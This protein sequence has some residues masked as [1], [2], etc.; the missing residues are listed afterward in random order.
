MTAH[1]EQTTSKEDIPYLLEILNDTKSSDYDRLNV[2][3]PLSKIGGK[4]SVEHI[5]K[6]LNPIKDKLRLMLCDPGS[7]TDAMN[8]VCIVEL[9][10]IKDTRIVEILI[11]LLKNNKNNCIGLAAIKG[12]GNTGDAKAIEHIIPFMSSNNIKESRAASTSLEKLKWKPGNQSE[13]IRYLI[14]YNKWD[15]LVKIGEPAVKPLI[16][17]LDNQ[18]YQGHGIVEIGFPAYA[19]G[20]IGDRRATFPLMSIL[21]LIAS[22]YSSD[23]NITAIWDALDKL[24][25]EWRNGDYI[26]RAVSRIMKGFRDKRDNIVMFKLNT[27]PKEIVIRHLLKLLDD[28]DDEDSIVKL[29][30]AS[31]LAFRG[32][33]RAVEPLIKI[34]TSENKKRDGKLNESAAESLKKLTGQD[35]GPDPEKWQKW[36][37]ENKEKYIDKK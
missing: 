8:T 33:K 24:D 35:Y 19:L 26:N 23:A 22:D 31:A 25:P 12:L 10:N 5:V 18:L 11:Y 37:E 13:K 28:L 36:W 30:V 4:H 20:E 9:G 15:E 7:V 21:T 2:I 1:A 29:R 6:F 3:I 27:F 14:A 17:A 32:E 34:I 16:K